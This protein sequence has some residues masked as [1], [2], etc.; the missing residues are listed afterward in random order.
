M[1][2]GL[3][4]PAVPAYSETFFRSKISGLVAHG[5]EVLLFV[6]SPTS[7]TNYCRARIVPSFTTQGNRF[8]LFIRALF[9]LFLLFIT[10]SKNVIRFLKLER[11]DGTP[12]FMILH[13][14][15]INSSLLASRLDWLHFGFGTM[16]LGKENVVEAI[17]A[18]MAVSFRG[19]DYYVYPVK[20]PNCYD[21]LYSKKVRYHVL[22][23][24]MKHG[25]VEQGIPEAIIHVISPA[26]ATNFFIRENPHIPKPYLQL[27][28]VGR[29]HWIKGLDYTL[30]AL[31]LL[32]Q[33]GIAFRYMIIGS[34]P[35][36]ERLRFTAHQLGIADLV[37]F[38]GMQTPETIKE[39][40]EQT[41]LYVQYS[42]QEG[43][44]NAVLEAQAMG[45]YCIVSDAEGLRENV[46][47]GVTG[48]VV[49]K[50]NPM[51]LTQ[52]IYDYSQLTKQEVAKR[53]L[54]A[55]ERV[56]L[57]FSIVQQQTHFMRFYHD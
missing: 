42:I 14:L 19:F 56:N 51:A 52:K 55:I 46:E 2:I 24:S 15:L 41:D 4:L 49:E 25:L 13:Q 29:L 34:G 22:S 23:Q 11:Q 57:N 12:S 1:K 54:Q 31:S 36:E 37:T 6:N 3:V 39:H 40:L 44:G 21:K 35:E 5:H 7:E 20:H 47:E 32:H 38:A 50:R 27:L 18:R 10:H 28:T 16:T 48:S 30:E 45:V 53:R 8:L 33:K 26:I 43:F 9:T 17:G